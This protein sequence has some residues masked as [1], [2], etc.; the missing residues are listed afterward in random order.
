MTA[1]AVPTQGSKFEKI[2]I[3][4]ADGNKTV[5]LRQG[6]AAFQYFENI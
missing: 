2:T 6:V 5:D 4:S 3:T 1:P